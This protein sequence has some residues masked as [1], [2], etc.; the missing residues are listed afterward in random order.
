MAV[1]TDLT[2]IAMRYADEVWNAQDLDA[3]D[4]LFTPDHVYHDTLLPDLPRGPEGVR[5]RRRVYLGAMPDARVTVHRIVADGE[6]VA[7]DWTYG[8][9]NTGEI[10]GMP[11]TGA[12]AT[13]TGSHFFRF[14]GRRI[15]ETWT[16]PDT[17][18]LLQ[19]LGLV[20]IGPAG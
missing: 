14:E 13:I 16:Y 20:T 18:G 2:A 17:L 11:A 9:T 4:D 8:G 6:L 15:A 5:E 1:T 10:M 19:Q 3:A 12:A 7:A